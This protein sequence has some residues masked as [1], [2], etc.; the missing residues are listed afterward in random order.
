[1][2]EIKEVGILSWKKNIVEGH[3]PFK[4]LK[5]E[6]V[7]IFEHRVSARCSSVLYKCWYLF[8]V[9]S[10]PHRKEKGNQLLITWN[11]TPFKVHVRLRMIVET[12][13]REGVAV[14]GYTHI[15]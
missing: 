6:E 10:V 3:L 12:F 15:I 11:G 8:S 5:G 13:G 9:L 1:M 7:K 14:G 4:D 2:R